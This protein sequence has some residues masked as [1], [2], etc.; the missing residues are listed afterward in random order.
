[1]FPRSIRR[2]IAILLCIK[3]AALILIYHAFV[4]P[5]SRPEPDSGAMAAYLLHDSGN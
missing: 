3:A 4:A 1:M 2:E 5:A